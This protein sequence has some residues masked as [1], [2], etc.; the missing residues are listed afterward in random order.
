M[1]QIEIEQVDE[2][3]SNW[4]DYEP[5]FRVYLHGS[6]EQST[7]GW[8]DTYDITGADVLQVIDWA[9]RQAGDSL[10]YAVALVYDDEAEGQRN[11]DHQRGLVWL[12]GIDGN[13][14]WDPDEPGTEA[15]RRMLVRRGNPVGVPAEDRM[16][17]GVPDPYR[18]G[19]RQR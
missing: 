16:P 11:P 13:D 6:G 9:Q 17:A 15:Q 19:S 5:R 10:T 4:E 8:T 2:R 18:D 12:V 7:K 14:V 3:D 1:S